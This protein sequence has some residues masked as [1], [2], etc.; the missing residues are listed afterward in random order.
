MKHFTLLLIQSSL[1]S[2]EEGVT[3]SIVTYLNS[4]SLDDFTQSELIND[5]G[6]IGT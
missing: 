4:E 2:W 6:K 3:T 5:R 1:E